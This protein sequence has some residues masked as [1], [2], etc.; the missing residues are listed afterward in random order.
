MDK[1]KEGILDN[2][3]KTIL[4][5]LRQMDQKLD[6]IVYKTS[7][8]GFSLV[9][10]MIVV[11][12]IGVLTA[13]AI[14]NFQRFQAQA[15]QS[16]AKSSLTGIY[17]AAKA[18]HSKWEAYAA[19]FAA[20]GYQPGGDFRYAV[21]WDN[22]YTAGN[23]IA[24]TGLDLTTGTPCNG[25]SEI[26]AGPAPGRAYTGACPGAGVTHN[27]EIYCGRTLAGGLDDGV[28]GCSYRG[29]AAVNAQLNTAVGAGVLTVGVNMFTAGA[30]ADLEG[31]Q[32]DA[33]DIGANGDVW[34]ID[35]L[36]NLINTRDQVDEAF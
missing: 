13:I 31:D 16:E 29:L 36:K 8:R 22:A 21:G 14:P 5:K 15:R 34:T 28:N 9:E 18:F 24:G 11:A 3:L 7:K 17:T 30:L 2:M 26:E 12:I 20:I 27:T 32:P 10:L 25:T 19:P 35:H 6:R 33:T 4:Q 23:Q 1:F